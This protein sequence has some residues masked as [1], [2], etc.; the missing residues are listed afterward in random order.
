MVRPLSLTSR[1]IYVNTFI[2]SIFAYHMLFFLLPIEYYNQL[3]TA[4]R[5]LVI[6]FNGSGL[7]YGSL[8]CANS[9]WHTRPALK[10]PWAFNLSLLAARSPLINSTANFNTLPLIHVNR[11]MLI[12][13]S[14]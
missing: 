11:S 3:V 8:V 5:R 1:I 13:R 10:D 6:P 4:I 9:L 2:V 7:T 14:S 12:Y